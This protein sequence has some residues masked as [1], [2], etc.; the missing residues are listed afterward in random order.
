MGFLKKRVVMEQAEIP[1]CRAGV[2]WAPWELRIYCFHRCLRAPVI[3]LMGVSCTVS[4]RVSTII[5][6][7]RYLRRLT[8]V[9]RRHRIRGME[10]SRIIDAL[11]GTDKAA[12]LCGLSK[13]AISQWRKRGI[14][15]AWRMYLQ[16][17][18]PAAFKGK[19]A[20]A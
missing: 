4:L 7:H 20:A 16:K 6:S 18:R 11:G 3:E 19:R 10:D 13:S 14:P 17:I 8:S 12:A 15:D 1:G 5:F 9:N 2:V